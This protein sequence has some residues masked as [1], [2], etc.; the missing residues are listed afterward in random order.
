MKRTENSSNA[1]T[2]NFDTNGCPSSV[3]AQIVSYNGKVKKPTT[4]EYKYT[5]SYGKQYNFVLENW[6]NGEEV[7][8]FDTDVVKSN[9][10]LKRRT[11]SPATCT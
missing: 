4:P 10:T 6:Y 3:S 7:W 9:V 11:I 1:V 5:D 8:N 2:V